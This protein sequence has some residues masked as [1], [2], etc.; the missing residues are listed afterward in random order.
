MYTLTLLFRSGAQLIR[1]SNTQDVAYLFAW[2][3]TLNTVTVEAD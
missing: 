3:P 2:Y 1:Y